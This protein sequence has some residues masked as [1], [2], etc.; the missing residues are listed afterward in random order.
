MSH[1]AE[2]FAQDALICI[3]QGRKATID[4][5][6]VDFMRKTL[7]RRDKRPYKLRAGYE[8]P[9]EHPNRH[10]AR[11]QSPDDDLQFHHLLAFI[12]GKE[13][14]MII[15]LYKWEF[16]LREIGDTFGVSESCVCMRMKRIHEKIRKK[17]TAQ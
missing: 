16:T 15:L 4:Q 3:V 1:Y 7:G 11:S 12:N 8:I 17:L 9:L 2:D 14:A 10:A 6:F 13:R 5:L